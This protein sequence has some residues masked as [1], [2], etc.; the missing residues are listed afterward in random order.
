MRD[1]SW[2]GV[3]TSFVLLALA[4][5]L[6]SVLRARARVPD[7][8]F[9]PL[10]ARW[11]VG[12]DWPERRGVTTGDRPAGEM[13]DLA[14]YARDDFDPDDVHPAVRRFYERTGDYA[15]VFD[16]HWHRPFRLGAALA[17]PVTSLLEQLNLPGPRSEDDGPWTLESEFLDVDSAA[18]PREGARAWV[19]TAA[20]TGAAVFVAVYGSHV[21]DD[22]RY[23]NIA[24]PLPHSN[25][26]TVLHLSHFDGTAE[27][28]GLELTTAAAGDPGLY[29][30]TP[31]GTFELPVDQT[32]RVWPPD[33]PNAPD[34][35]DTPDARTDSDEESEEDTLVATHEMWLSGRQFLTVTY[36]VQTSNS[37][38]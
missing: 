6:R 17:A 36:R 13:D 29:L 5:A 28:T 37:T 23:V 22:E 3:L 4:V 26:S 1:R 30:V 8:P 19:R 11:R 14:A 7:A 25:L 31:L 12:P 24:A 38:S 20:E 21:S 33:A 27:G 16:V 35:P 2:L 15:M 34:A 9:S 10:T 32:F 18:D